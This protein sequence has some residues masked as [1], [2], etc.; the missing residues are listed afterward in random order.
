MLRVQ[1][2]KEAIVNLEN[3]KISKSFYKIKLLTLFLSG[4]S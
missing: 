4:A 3:F 2:G 1:R